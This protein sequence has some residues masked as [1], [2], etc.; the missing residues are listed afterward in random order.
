MHNQRW[1]VGILVFAVVALTAHG[2]LAGVEPSPFKLKDFAPL[3]K[4]FRAEIANAHEKLKGVELTREMDLKKVNY[5]SNSIPAM[6]GLVKDMSTKAGII[7]DCGI[8]TKFE[9]YIQSLGNILAIQQN[10]RKDKV[11]AQKALNEMADILDKMEAL[12]K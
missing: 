9:G 11:S 1:F 2:A 5:V 8:K 3:V 12:M 6:Q 7:G 10:N 4:D